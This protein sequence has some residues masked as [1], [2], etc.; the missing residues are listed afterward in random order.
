MSSGRGPH[1][2]DT[3]HLDACLVALQVRVGPGQLL[4]QSVDDSFE[5]RGLVAL[6]VRQ[7]NLRSGASLYTQY[8]EAASRTLCKEGHMSVIRVTP[9]LAALVVL[10]GQSALAQAP[11]PAG[12]AMKA[13]AS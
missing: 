5:G 11:A 1:G 3:G 7:G 12:E 10:A 6:L 9:L 8:R 2:R 4:E 13:T